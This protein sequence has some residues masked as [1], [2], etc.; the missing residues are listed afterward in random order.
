MVMRILVCTAVCAAAFII[1]AASASAQGVE[2]G[3]KAGITSA[4]LSVTG[5]PG[6]D[7]DANV[8]MLAGGWV[9]GGKESVRVQAEVLFTSRRF[10]SASPF[11]DIDVSSSAV[12]VP[13]LVVGRW[14]QGS[15]TRPL[16]LAG[17]Y[18]AFIVKSTQTVGATKTDI[19]DQI[20]GTDLGALLGLGVEIAARRGAVVL[21]TRFA[22]GLRDLSEASETTFKSRTVMVSFG[23]RF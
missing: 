7:P 8:G 1:S 14:R 18:V 6:F 20:K 11:G 5:L 15:R 22:V 17:P 4:T 12:D 23:Y 16:L 3:L 10:S 2:G 21:E 19:G 13:V 9:S